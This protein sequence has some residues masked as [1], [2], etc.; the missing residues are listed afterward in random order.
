VLMTSSSTDFLLVR[1]LLIHLPLRCVRQLLRFI[2]EVLCHL[3]LPRSLFRLMP[4]L[5]YHRLP[6]M[7]AAPLLVM[8]PLL[9]VIPI[10][11]LAVPMQ[12]PVPL[13][14]PSASPRGIAEALLHRSRVT[15]TCI[16][17]A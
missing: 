12:L 10:L 16:R 2:V 8:I 17:L 11:V 9:F 3:H 6:G 15:P 4:F 7:L 14:S 13:P 5:V 1:P